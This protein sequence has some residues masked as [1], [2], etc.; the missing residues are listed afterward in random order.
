[1]TLC[2]Y[3]VF[4]SITDSSTKVAIGASRRWMARPARLVKASCWGWGGVCR[5]S[6]TPPPLPLPPSSLPFR[7]QLALHQIADG[8]LGWL[9]LEQHVGDLARDRQLNA[10][11]F[12]ERNRGAGR[13]D[14]FHDGG[15]PRQ[16]LL[17]RLA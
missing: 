5:L 3:R 17:E 6:L 13:V 14:P 4:R 2:F 11:P 8:L 15:L 7:F 10:V 16:R 12:A 1:C 9:V